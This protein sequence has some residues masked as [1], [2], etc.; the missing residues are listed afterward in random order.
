MET[1]VQLSG[2]APTTITNV[3][4]LTVLLSG[5]GT[6]AA[7]LFAVHYIDSH[8]GEHVMSFYVHAFIPLGAILVGLLASSGYLISSLI[9]GMRIGRLFLL[10]IFLLQV[11]AYFVGEYIE[12]RSLHLVWRR[13]G[14]PMGF[15]YYFHLRSISYSLVGGREGSTSL[16][17]FGYALRLLEIGS[18]GLVGLALP[19]ALR[20]S[21]YCES[22]KTYMSSRE[23]ALFPASLPYRKFG[24][25][26]AEDRQAY[27]EEQ[28][29]LFEKGVQAAALLANLAESGEGAELCDVMKSA[30]SA[31][32][33][34]AKLPSRIVL[35]MTYCKRCKEGDMY[36]VA[37]AGASKRQLHDVKLDPT[38]VASL[39][40][41][42]S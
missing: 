1:E 35:S 37:N 25:D 5:L 8:H 4:P 30:Q 38:V 26:E 16:G 18:F 42:E 7:S 41:K 23:L 10:T 20:H 36:I 15:W 22:C 12:F 21:A 27:Q 33:E 9:S 2:H 19:S 39:L 34:T 32:R 40:Q 17:Y 14:E 11:I 28:E 31:R 13:T 29:E 24:T 3:N 6:T